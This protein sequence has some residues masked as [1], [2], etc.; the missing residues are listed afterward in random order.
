MLELDAHSSLQAENE[1]L[2][3]D[4]GKLLHLLNHAAHELRTPLTSIVGFSEF[5]HKNVA[6]LS[7]EKIQY[8]A[9]IIRQEGERL[10]RIVNQLLDLSRLR[11]GKIELHLALHDLGNLLH[12]CAQNLEFQAKDKNIEITLQIENG[13][14]SLSLDADKIQQVWTNLLANAL[15]YS[16][17]GTIIEAG[18]KA[19]TDEVLCWVKDQGVGITPQHLAGIFDEFYRIENE[20]IDVKGSGLGLPISKTIIELHGGRIWVESQPEHGSTFFFTLPSQAR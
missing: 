17:E 11:S 2:R 4:N 19:Q 16:F 7:H 1:Q 20:Q 8:Y 13:F 14:P 9:E 18:I 5:I 15:H 3:Q 10:S 12:V 6:R